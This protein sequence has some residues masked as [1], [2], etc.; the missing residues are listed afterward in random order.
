MLGGDPGALFLAGR[1][2]SPLGYIN[3]E[4]CAFAMACWFSLALAERREPVL[5]GLG[6]G[7]TVA[8]ACLTLLSQSRGAAI[9]LFAALVIVFAVVPGAR[10][11]VLA[12]ALVAVGVAVAAGPVDR[13]YST[14]QAGVVAA[15]V[16][17]RAGVAILLAALATGLVWAAIVG[18]GA[19]LETRGPHTANLLQRAATVL[20]VLILAA[21]V[22]AAL[23]RS[24][25]IERTLR[26]QWNACV[27][28]SDV[29]SSSSGA[30]QTRLFSGAGNRYDYWRIAWHAFT[31]HPVLGVGAGNYAT[32]YYR[33]RRTLESIENPHSLELQTLSELGV[34]G[35]LLL[36]LAIAG[37]GLGALSMRA[38][39]RRVPAARTMMV[40]ATGAFVVWLVDTSGDWM[41]LLPGMTAVALAAAVVLCRAGGF[42][43]DGEPEELLGTGA[44]AS[45]GPG[46]LR[47]GIGTLAGAA[48]V[49]FVLAVTGA[50]LLRAGLVRHYLDSARAEL[51][52]N[53]ARAV[54]DANRALRLDGAN[55]DAYEVKAAGE[56][57]F[58]NAAAARSTLLT[59]AREDPQ[60]FVT[61]AL[62]GDLEVRL[63]DFEAARMF[64]SRAHV[65]DPND[66][67]I[68]AL[69]ANPV[70]AL[71]R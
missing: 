27:H 49:A 40:A 64:Y 24:S 66:P 11:R 58:D 4:G 20:A 54:T 69:A 35:A 34:V 67:G 19:M 14:G 22:V 29:G 37:V 21:P 3:G 68:A 31:A 2:N 61:W 8:F 48:V 7:A 18:V 55:L 41:H 59:A 13:I 36:A 71:P 16:S 50:S 56:A 44:S 12:L 52:T 46:R 43:G 70:S 10:R 38:V 45:V 26:T 5:A 65:L 53:P 28:L 15:S 32:V 9:A 63:H 39:A 1:L 47:V 57:R 60:D 42:D 30:A 33:Q 62:L 6:A 23:L 17:H 25:T 51:A